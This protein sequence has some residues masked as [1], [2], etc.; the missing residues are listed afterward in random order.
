MCENLFDTTGK[1]ETNIS[2]SIY[3]TPYTYQSLIHK[4]GYIHVVMEAL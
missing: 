4:R 2:N 3:V 1:F